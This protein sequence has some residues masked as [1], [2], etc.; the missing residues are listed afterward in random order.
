MITLTQDLHIFVFNI[1]CP[2][3]N[4]CDQKNL[5]LW[6]IQRVTSS[7]FKLVHQQCKAHHAATVIQYQPEVILLNAPQ[8]IT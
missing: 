5:T 6:C 2:C 8:Q 7:L 4:S 1:M 3:S